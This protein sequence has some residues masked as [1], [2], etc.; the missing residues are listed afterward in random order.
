MKKGHEKEKEDEERIGE[1][2]KNMRG[3]HSKPEEQIQN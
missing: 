3:S 1:E 2:H